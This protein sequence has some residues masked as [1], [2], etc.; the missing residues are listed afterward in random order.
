MRQEQAT[1][2]KD[3]RPVTDRTGSVRIG[4]YSHSVRIGAIQHFGVRATRQP[5]PLKPP[6]VMFSGTQLDFRR[7][8]CLRRRSPFSDVDPVD[9]PR[10][11]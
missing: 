7:G 11:R 1:R 3:A 8:L 2:R 10:S 5:S 6:V 4:D 9:E